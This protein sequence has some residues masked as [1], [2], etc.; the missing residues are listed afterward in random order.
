MGRLLEGWLRRVA[1]VHDERERRMQTVCVPTAGVNDTL[2]T[3][4]PDEH[5]RAVAATLMIGNDDEAGIDRFACESFAR[6]DPR[7]HRAVAFMGYDNDPR[8]LFDIPEACRKAERLLF[9]EH[10]NVRPFIRLLCWSDFDTLTHVV[11]PVFKAW[12]SRMLGP[13]A[14]RGG[15]AFPGIMFLAALAAGIKPRIVN[16]SGGMRWVVPTTL[17]FEHD[18][19]RRVFGRAGKSHLD[20]GEIARLFRRRRRPK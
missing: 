12:R 7:C 11:P 15:N 6:L 18:L 9:D 17:A 3:V 5:G 4:F 20:P 1:G 10:G 2:V 13:E 16:A 19:Q 8:E 14:R